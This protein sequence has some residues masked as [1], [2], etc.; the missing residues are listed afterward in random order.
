M[1]ITKAPNRNNPGVHLVDLFARHHVDLVLDVGARNGESGELLRDNGYRG[2]IV[3]FEP[4]S[5]TFAQLKRRCDADPEWSCRQL[6]LG[7]SDGTADINVTNYSSFSSLRNPTDLAGARFGNEVTITDVETV[8][9][10]RLDDIWDEVASG[11]RS[12]FLKV[13][14]QGWDLEVLAGAT[15]HLPEVGILQTEMSLHSVY[16]GSPSWTESLAVLASYGFEPSAFVPVTKHR[17]GRLIEMDCVAIR[18]PYGDA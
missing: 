10:R 9:V 16:E 15:E 6:A 1:D 12:V 7:S 18:K 13:D 14:T 17:D 4:V 5:S 2:R 11:A 3:S 8:Q